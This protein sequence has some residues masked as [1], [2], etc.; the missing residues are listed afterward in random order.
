MALRSIREARV[1][2][3]AT[4]S[5]RCSSESRFTASR[6]GVRDTSSWAAI[7]FSSITSPGRMMPLRISPRTSG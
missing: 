7:A 1:P 6:T 4:T 3:C 5:T 2:D